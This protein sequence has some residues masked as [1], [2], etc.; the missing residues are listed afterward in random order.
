[1]NVVG[2]A[3]VEGAYTPSVSLE[4]LGLA[5]IAGQIEWQTMMKEELKI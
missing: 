5:L 1:M 4:I 2:R 3:F